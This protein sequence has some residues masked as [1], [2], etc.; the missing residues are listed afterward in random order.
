MLQTINVQCLK[1]LS[2][3]NTESVSEP[4]IDLLKLKMTPWTSLTLITTSDENGI[5]RNGKLVQNQTYHPPHN[6]QLVHSQKN[7]F[8]FD[9]YTSLPVMNLYIKNFHC[10]SEH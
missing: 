2:E 7:R 10:P 5:F 9:Y 4:L 8:I 1:P 3:M 6:N